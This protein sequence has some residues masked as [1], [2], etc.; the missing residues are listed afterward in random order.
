VTGDFPALASGLRSSTRAPA[1]APDHR[2]SFRA[3]L[4][5]P[6]TGRGTRSP[7]QVKGTATADRVKVTADSPA[8]APGLR[9]RSRAESHGSFAFRNSRVPLQRIGSKRDTRSPLQLQGF[10]PADRVKETADFP[11]LAS[12]LRYS[13]KAL[14]RAPDHRSRSRASL[15]RP[16]RKSRL[17]FRRWLQS[18]APGQ[19]QK[20][21]AVLPSE[22]PGYRYNGSGQRETPDHRYS[23]R[24]SLQ[25]QGPGKATR[26]P[27]QLQG[28]APSQ[29]V[30]VRPRTPLQVKGFATASRHRQGHQITAPGQRLHS[31]GSGRK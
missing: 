14:A 31:S 25:H 20:V 15:Q 7:L 9:S 1:R 27:P 21:T 30:K 5:R 12:G 19:G 29:G 11:A 17:I 6:G 26:S 18:F 10:A 23:F 16:G 24:A 3:S 4:Q 13:T 28:F 2:Y 8:L 22:I